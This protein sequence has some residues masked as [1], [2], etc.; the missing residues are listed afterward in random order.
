M[1]ERAFVL[2]FNTTASAVIDSIGAMDHHALKYPSSSRPRTL[3]HTATP[4]TIAEMSLAVVCRLF[5]VSSAAANMSHAVPAMQTVNKCRPAH[6]LIV[7]KLKATRQ[8][9]ANN[10][11]ASAHG[12]GLIVRVTASQIA[13]TTIDA[14][15]N[16][17]R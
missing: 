10:E 11:Q 1:C 16:Q 8:L 5:P 6:P 13:A 12:E 15:L 9:A 2:K 3:R 17:P 7:E 4:P 14:R